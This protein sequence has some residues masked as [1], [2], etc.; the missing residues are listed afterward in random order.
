MLKGFVQQLPAL[1][2]ALA[3]L[4]VTWFAARFA[5]NIAE[6]MTRNAHMRDN[7]KQLSETLVR[8]GIWLVGLM[9]AA[10]VA[11]PGLTPGSLLA[12]LGFGAVAIGFAF[13][14]I[15]QNFLA[16]VLIMLRDKMRIGD[17]IKCQGI[18][19]RVER[20]MLR[21]THVRSP[22]NELTIVPNS[23]L[24]KNPVE[25]LTDSPKRRFELVVN[26]PKDADLDRATTVI[27]DTVRE[28]DDVDAARGVDVYAQEI[29][30]ETVDVLVRWWAGSRPHD[31]R[32]TRDAIIRR[33]R[34]A[35]ADLVMKE[36]EPAE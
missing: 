2:I 19:G 17:L 27:K 33:V 23:V 4:I 3:I 10:T 11:M 18:E 36:A 30:G 12:G 32:A 24:F 28:V 9:I 5:V 1:A 7:L 31:M 22:S 13:Q 8:L 20:I 16:G 26:V 25:I 29:K 6:R 35:I 14:D 21:E 15:F 34:A